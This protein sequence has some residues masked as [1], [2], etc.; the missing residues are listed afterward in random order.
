MINKDML[1]L[2]FRPAGIQRWND[3]IR[4]HTGFSELD[5]QSHKMVFAY[6]LGKTE[7]SDR[8]ITIDWR[9]LIEG[10]I[11]EFLQRAI[12]TDLKPAVF[13]RLMDEKKQ[14]L[15]TWVLAELDTALE[16]LDK[17]FR[18]NLKR[19]L[20]ADNYCQNEKRVLSAAH[21]LATQWEFKIIYNLNS[22]LYGLEQTK[23]EIENELEEYY[24]LAGVQKLALGKKLSGFMDQVGMLRFQQRWAQTPRIPATSVMGHM[25]IVAIMVYLFSLEL[26]AC[27]KR[28]YNNFFAGLFH[29]LPEVLTRDIIS[30]VKRA[31]EGLEAIIKDIEQIQFRERIFPL[32]PHGWHAEMA[33]FLDNEFASKAVIDNTLILC[34][35]KELSDNYN[36]S[37]CNPLDGEM[38]QACDQLAAYIEAALSIEYGMK[39]PD[40]I[41]GKTQIYEKNAGTKVDGIDFGTY[42]NFFV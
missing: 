7:E 30:P 14:E 17:S 9:R 33:Y 39:A 3:H 29:D 23:Q 36:H 32:L 35:S 18:D 38:I 13:H 31:V 2:L 12:L 21:Y 22:G 34:S 25:L 4:P 24:D 11:F 26:G 8:N 37:N 19:Y 41:K 28:T 20:L 16:G 1:N 27:E 42:F 10:C 40:L 6:I 5:K 15:N